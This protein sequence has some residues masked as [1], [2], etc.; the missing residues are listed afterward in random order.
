MA[1][2]PQYLV[3]TQYD[4]RADGFS[5]ICTNRNAVVMLADHQAYYSDETFGDAIRQVCKAQFDI[6]AKKNDL[7]NLKEDVEHK[8][9]YQALAKIS[10]AWADLQINLHVLIAALKEQKGEEEGEGRTIELVGNWLAAARIANG[11]STEAVKEHNQLTSYED[12]MAAG[13]GWLGCWPL[14]AGAYGK[15]HL[16]TRLNKHGQICNKIVV[17][18]CDFGLD[19]GQ[20]YMWDNMGW[21]WATDRNQP[22]VPVEV[23]M[24][25]DLRGR[26]GAEFVVK[27]LNWR[28]ARERRLFRLYLEVR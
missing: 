19:A 15:T 22:N 20:R 5:I 23:Q 4:S 10:S 24:M 7:A 14:G 3:R 27:I 25:S 17:K 28:I 1:K 13:E 12:A 18:D 11:K 16:Y 6:D 21:L 2:S 26:I 8:D 9:K